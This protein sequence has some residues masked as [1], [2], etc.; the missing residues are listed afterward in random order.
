VALPRPKEREIYL[1]R[2]VVMSQLTLDGVMQGLGRPDGGTRGGFKRGG[3]AVSRGD[4]AMVAKMSERMGR[5]HAFLYG[6]RT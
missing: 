1:G 6:R 4:E 5:D 3:W 2:I